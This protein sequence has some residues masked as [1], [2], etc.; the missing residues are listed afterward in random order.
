MNDI[1]NTN[2]N[3]GAAEVFEE[4]T[5]EQAASRLEE[6]VEKL[7]SGETPLGETVK[8]YEQGIALSDYCMKLLA[9]YDGR[10]EKVSSAALMEELRRIGKRYLKMN[11]RQR[12]CCPDCNTRIGLSCAT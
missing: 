4:L 12:I 2:K 5:F 3:C 6:I 1:D 7:D 11:S 10:I 8:L 9:D